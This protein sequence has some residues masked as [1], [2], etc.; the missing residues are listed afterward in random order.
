MHDHLSHFR[1]TVSSDVE[2][3]VTFSSDSNED[4]D[5]LNKDDDDDLEPQQRK[6]TIWTRM[7]TQVIR[8]TRMKMIRW[9]REG[10]ISLLNVY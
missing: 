3:V 9:R 5:D 4:D 7:E 2:R 6:M 10:L 1:I 8:M